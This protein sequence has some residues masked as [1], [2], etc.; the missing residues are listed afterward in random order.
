MEV[1]SLLAG[2]AIVFRILAIVS[3]DSIASNLSI[4][5]DQTNKILAEVVGNQKQ[6]KRNVCLEKK[7]GKSTRVHFHKISSC[8]NVIF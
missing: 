2:V 5:F 4:Y 1:L 7:E 6:E 3:E 8:I